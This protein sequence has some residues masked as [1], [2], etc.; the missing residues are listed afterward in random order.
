MQLKLRTLDIG[1]NMI[2]EI[3]GISHLTELEEFWV[4][5]PPSTIMRA[6]DS[7]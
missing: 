3:E 6:G 7:S 4:S 5:S 2:E 1:N